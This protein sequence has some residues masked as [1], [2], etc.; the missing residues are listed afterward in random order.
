[1]SED[2]QKR[3]VEELQALNQTLQQQNQRIERLEKMVDGSSVQPREQSVQQEGQAKTS[4]P[5]QTFVQPFD[6]K[7]PEQKEKKFF[8]KEDLEAKLGGNYLQKIG[9]AAVVLG[10]VFFLKYSFDNGWIGEI[11]RIVIGVIAGIGL[12]G[13]G[14]YFHKKYAHW[15]KVFTGGGFVLLYFTFYA[16]HNFY[17]LMSAA[18][19]FAIMIIITVFA[20]VFA[21]RYDSKIVA[22]YA[23][24]GGYVAPILIESTTH[25]YVSLFMYLVVLSAG[26]LGLNHF[27]KWK[28]LNI[29]AFVFT[30]V[31]SMALSHDLQLGQAVFFALVFFALFALLAFYYNVLFKEKTNATDLFILIAN[32][33]LVYGNL[34]FLL[35]TKYEQ[36]LG[37]LAF[38]FAAI[39]LIQAYYVFN[40]HR[41]DALLTYSLLGMT[42]AGI[43]VGLA[44]QLSGAWITIGWT[45]LALGLLWVGLTA[46]HRG[47]RVYAAIMLLLGIFR[48]FMFD[49][50]V[51]LAESGF[52]TVFNT[53]FAA[54]LIVIVALYIGAYL[55]MQ[56]KQ[57]LPEDEQKMAVY[58][59]L[60]ANILSLTVLTLE[61]NSYFEAQYIKSQVGTAPAIQNYTLRRDL[62]QTTQV[63]ISIAWALYAIALLIVGILKRVKPIRLLALLVFGIALVKVVF[64]D[65][66]GMEQVYRIIAFIGFGVILIA[67]SYLYQR[68]KDHIKDFILEEDAEI[69]QR[70][71]AEVAQSLNTIIEQTDITGIEKVTFQI[72]GGQSFFTSH[73]YILK[74]SKYVTK[75]FNKQQ[76]V[77]GELKTVWQK[78]MQEYHPHMQGEDLKRV[79]GRLEEFVNRGG[80]I[81]F[82]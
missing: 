80:T 67:A 19:A 10:L 62:N 21:V 55:Y 33:I 53:R 81:T 18:S 46:Q 54:Y 14:E 37:I 66:N 41:D 15:A 23:I 51:R 1:M 52:T 70:V 22:T 13:L 71:D 4:I 40:K 64:V 39:Y 78:F 43:A 42:V 69:K 75:A 57:E 5:E 35:E 28:D 9:I 82:T 38:V 34:Y 72:S 20:A 26:I 58:V 49:S 6:T 45:V 48:L 2:L 31:Y 73:E 56:H 3:L 11:G 8:D 59:S 29:L 30:G 65:M 50:Q 60:A 12:L 36:Y 44:V 61:I 17:D 74:I 7:Q 16:A 27:K 76:F 47:A 77:A 24:V 68:F 63:V 79:L 32:G 25:N